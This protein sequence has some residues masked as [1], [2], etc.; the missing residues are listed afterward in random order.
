MIIFAHKAS[1]QLETSQQMD[2][3]TG[4]NDSICFLDHSLEFRVL[5]EVN[6]ITETMGGGPDLLLLKIRFNILSSLSTHNAS[7]QL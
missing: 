4:F 6:R 7:L 1:L 5:D 3:G 2:P